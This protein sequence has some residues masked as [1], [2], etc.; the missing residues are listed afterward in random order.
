MALKLVSKDQTLPVVIADLRQ[1]CWVDGTDQDDYLLDLA[2]GSHELIENYTGRNFTTTVYDDQFPCFG[3]RL[4]LS[5]NGTV[6]SVKYYDAD[7]TQVTMAATDYYLYQDQYRTIITLKDTAPTLS[8]REDAVVV[9]ITQTPSTDF[10]VYYRYRRC[11]MG[12]VKHYF[13]NRDA[14]VVG[15]INSEL[16]LGTQRLLDSLV[17][18]GYR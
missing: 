11:L 17:L 3:A 5:I 10:G 15:S 9:R 18:V 6:D 4:Q 16:K 1:H 14:I 7:D 12:L 13:E 8:E 2:H